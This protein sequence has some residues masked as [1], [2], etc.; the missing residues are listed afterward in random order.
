MFSRDP[1]SNK[2]MCSRGWYWKPFFE[3]ENPS[4]IRFSF[5]VI[6]F[7]IATSLILLLKSIGALNEHDQYWW[8]RS[9]HVDL[10]II[11]DFHSYHLQACLR[12]TS[13]FF[14]FCLV[15]MY[16]LFPLWSCLFQLSLQVLNA[17]CFVWGYTQ[18]LSTVRSV[19]PFRVTILNVKCSSISWNSCLYWVLP[20]HH[21]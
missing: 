16:V 6:V 11:F 3:K 5:I 12:H 18:P 19:S 2:Y 4:R 14:L 1:T 21:L 17:F 15:R 10:L 8:K 9:N 13:P 7:D 20:F